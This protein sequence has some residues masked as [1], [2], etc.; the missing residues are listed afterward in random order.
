VRQPF[1]AWL[2]TLSLHHPFDDFPAR[3]KVLHVGALEGTP[4]GNYLHTMHFFDDA[5]DAFVRSLASSGLLD[6]TVLVVFGDH[7]AGFARSAG[8]ARTIGIRSGEAAWTLNDRVPVFVRVPGGAAS[9]LSGP[10][11]VAA[12]QTDVAPTILSLVGIDA[13]ELPYVGRN[14]LGA[15]GDGPVPRPHGDWLDGRH[16][17]LAQDAGA[18]CRDAVSLAAVAGGANAC[19]D[20]DRR[21]RRERDVSRLVVTADLQVRLRDVMRHARIETR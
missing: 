11:D 7:D 3:H 4:F 15:P 6:K 21:A 12:G 16:L 8:L 17:Y 10:R 18:A 14:L 19:T 5:L 13:A 20:A 9:G 1:A 2:I